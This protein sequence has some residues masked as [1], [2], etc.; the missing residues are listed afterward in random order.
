MQSPYNFN[1]NT[2]ILKCKT[3]YRM[4][5]QSKIPAIMVNK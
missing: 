1:T 4:G 3:S 2:H 5:K